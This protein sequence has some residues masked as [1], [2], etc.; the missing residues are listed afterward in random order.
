MAVRVRTQNP[1]ATQHQRPRH[2]TRKRASEQ[3]GVVG[4][5]L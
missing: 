3:L 5:H 2:G 1:G 4:R